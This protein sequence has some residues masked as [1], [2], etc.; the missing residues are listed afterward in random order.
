MFEWLSKLGRKQRRLLR[1]LE[2]GKE[3]SGLDLSKETGFSVG[4]TYSYLGRLER[5]G[6]VIGRVIKG[7]SERRS[8]LKKLW[9]ITVMGRAALS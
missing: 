1:A 2:D 6:A 5:R 8:L 4:V 7:G 9:S 3:K